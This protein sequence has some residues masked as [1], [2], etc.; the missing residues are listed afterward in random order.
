MKAKAIVDRTLQK[1]YWLD[2]LMCVPHLTRED[3]YV[4]PGYGRHDVRFWTG[5][6]MLL[7]GA[8]EGKHLLADPKVDLPDNLRKVK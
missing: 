3:A 2:G 7:M 8:K 4:R 5:Q 1:V 6:Q